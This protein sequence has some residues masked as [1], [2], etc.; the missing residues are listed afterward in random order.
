MEEIYTI[1]DNQLIN[2]CESNISISSDKKYF[3][4]GSSK[5]EIYVFNLL[6]GKVNIINL[7]RRNNR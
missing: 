2:Y 4:C 1:G 3:T 5:G 6:T 7:E